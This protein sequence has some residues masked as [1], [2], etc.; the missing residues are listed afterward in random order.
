MTVLASLSF[1]TSVVLFLRLA[2]RLITWRRKTHVRINQFIILIFNLVIADMQQSVAF[3]LNVLWLRKNAIQSNTPAC[4]AQGWFVSIGDLSSGVFTLTIAVHAFMDI[5]W[6][7]RLGHKAFLTVVLFLWTFVYMCAIIG[8]ALHPDDYYVRAGAWCWVNAKYKI[9]RLWL[10]YFWVIIAEFGTVILYAL[11]FLILRQRVKRSFYNNTDTQIRAESAAKVIVAY[12]VVYVVCTLPLVIA[13]LTSMAGG[14]LDFV[15]LCV[16][17]AMITSNGWLDVLLYTL[18]R[19]ALIFGPDMPGEHARALD[20]FKF[21]PDHVYGT[22]TTIEASH[23]V[24]LASNRRRAPD[25]VPHSGHDST[26]ELCDWQGVKAETVVQVRTETMELVTLGSKSGDA[27]Q[28]KIAASIDSR[29]Q[30]SDK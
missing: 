22:T 28:R 15:K 24:G 5:V 19:R 18:T 26:E 29:S 16:A 8:V 23:T 21:R 14:R 17:G 7:R 2:Y 20:T 3:L 25:G 6:D 4:W 13:R 12:P 30:K 1:Y 9:E 10:H 11:T 27:D